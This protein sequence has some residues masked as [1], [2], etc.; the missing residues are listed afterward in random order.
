VLYDVCNVSVFT[1]IY[2]AGV[3]VGEGFFTKRKKS[4][5]F[6]HARLGI[7]KILRFIL[8]TYID[9]HNDKHISYSSA[10]ESCN[11]AAVLTDVRF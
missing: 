4:F 3:V 6:Q 1:H 8:F 9:T 2:R 10:M 5:I 7:E 11:T